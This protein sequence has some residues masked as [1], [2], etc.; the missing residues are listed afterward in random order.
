MSRSFRAAYTLIELLVVVAI[1][2]VL[3]GLLLPAVQKV[4]ETASR[5][6]CQNH[7]KQIGLAL[8]QHHDAH[9]V[10]PSNGGWDGSQTIQATDG[11][12]FT[13]S[14]QD[15]TAPAPY[16]WGV[17]SPDLGPRQQTGSW[18]YTILPYLEQQ[19]VYSQRSWQ[20]PLEV[21]HCPTRRPPVATVPGSDQHATYN[22]GGWA[23]AKTDYAA[24]QFLISN[25]P[26]CRPFAAITDGL[27][28]TLMVGEKA[29][30]LTYYTQT[31]WFWDE[32]C[33]TG[34]SDSTARKGTQV[35]RDSKD[36]DGGLTFR[37]NWGAA[38]PAG[39]NFVFADGSVRAIA[40]ETSP[41]RVRALMTPAGGEVVAVD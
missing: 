30:S 14:T 40:H 15:Y 26:T 37:E 19:N 7:L 18:A 22:G 29:M 34:G 2:A 9:T 11:S 4:R 13:V 27:S 12:A 17:G 28:N 5:M 41:E 1:I 35:L 8:H 24:N 23:W 16:R 36:M 25:R 33:F 21:Y 20:T 6:R 39:T 31:G 10:L 3:V 32:P 38:H